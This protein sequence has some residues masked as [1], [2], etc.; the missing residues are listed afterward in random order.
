VH[1]LEL[2][3]SIGEVETHYRERPEGSSSKL[4]TYR[5][6]ARILLTILRL[7]SAERPVAFYGLAAAVLA[8]VA[9]AFA[10]PLL[11]TYLDTGLVPRFPT[12]ILATGLMIL[13]A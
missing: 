1:A 9:L 3:L 12:A 11:I 6:G 7:F 5:D 13:S 8:S 10:A 4:R 2:K